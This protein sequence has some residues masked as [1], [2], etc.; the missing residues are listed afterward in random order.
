MDL[1]SKNLR[2]AQTN[3]RTSGTMRKSAAEKPKATKSNKVAV[4]IDKSKRSDESLNFISG[5]LIEAQEKER[6]RMAHELHDNINQ[7]IAL[8]SIELEQLAQKAAVRGNGLGERIKSLQ[9]K[10]RDLSSEIHRLSYEL[11]PSKLDYFGL[12]AALSSLCREVAARHGLAVNFRDEGVQ[13]EPP[14]DVGLCIF[15]VAQESIDNAVRHSGASSLD[16]ELRRS[17][18]TIKL[19]VSDFGRGFDTG[20]EQTFNGL[21]FVSM[22]ERLRLLKGELKVSSKRSHGT[23]IEAMVPLH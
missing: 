16:V 21:G 17:G 1:F 8:I 9:V 11:H 7:R 3:G 5:R 23:R 12:S 6:S 18:R 19:F 20:S 2:L 22:R 13:I 14:V 10:T 15:R 4:E